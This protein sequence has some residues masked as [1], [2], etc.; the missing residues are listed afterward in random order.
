MRLVDRDGQCEALAAL[1]AGAADGRGGAVLLRGAPGHGKTALLG[2]LV[3]LAEGA[4]FRCLAAEP[5]ALPGVAELAGDR[6]GSPGGRE[7]VESSGRVEP[8][9]SGTCSTPGTGAR[10]GAVGRCGS[11]APVLV[12]VDD[13]GTADVGVL[14]DLVT[15]ARRAAVVLALTDLPRLPDADPL[16]TVAR[17]PGAV[18]LDLPP[19]RADTTA[20]LLDGTP[21][22][23]TGGNPAL[24]RALARDLAAGDA[25]PG[26]AYRAALAGLLDRCGPEVAATAH[27]T[28][29]LAVPRPPT[30]APPAPVTVDLVADLL[31]RAPATVADARARLAGA[32]LDQADPAAVLD[33]LPAA[34]RAELHLRAARTLHE[35]GESPTTVADHL[36]TAGLPAP[37]WAVD[38]LVA[39]ADLALAADDVPTAVERLTAA[40]R[41]DVDRRDADRRDANRPQAEPQGGGLDSD[42]PARQCGC[43]DR[44]TAP[45]DRPATPIPADRHAPPATAPVSAPAAV[46]GTAPTSASRVASAPAAVSG[47]ASVSGPVPASGAGS[48][49]VPGAAP[50]SVAGA[51]SGFG[52][53]PM[54]VP[55]SAPVSASASEPTSGSTFALVSAPLPTSVSAPVSGSVS[56]ARTGSAPVPT[57]VSAPASGA[58]AGTGAGF[59]PAPVPT[60]VSA[61]AFAF[62]AGAGVAPVPP[63]SHEPPPDLA[64]TARL[65]RA[66]WQLN[67]AAALCHLDPL[68]DA[69]AADPAALDPRDAAVL[70]RQ[71]VWHGRTTA[72]GRVLAA[73]RA[74][75]HAAELPDLETW[76]SLACPPLAASRRSTALRPNAPH[77]SAPHTSALHPSTPHPST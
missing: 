20:R 60:P 69:L 54:S 27:A 44:G 29:V 42:S 65:T 55:A 75:E 32:G 30:T 14:L 18:V 17:A 36:V 5:D 67:P 26:P 56:E 1:L 66:R 9:G 77:P 41:R 2:W 37:A 22:P 21:W 31:G 58:G 47:G 52:S 59:V 10:A 53:A 71:L 40:H 25:G 28:A 3:E 70:V 16:G 49:S 51:V 63:T 23:V 39:A 72:A 76:L 46:S 48:A 12:A 74:R 73:L 11:R 38:V 13:A 43:A 45:T 57:P 68:A 19:L 33:V 15:L 34:R 8:P 61:P 62:G 7:P 24:V 4:G 6:T 64:L 35:R 50:A